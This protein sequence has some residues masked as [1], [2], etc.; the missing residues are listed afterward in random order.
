MILESLTRAKEQ[1]YSDSERWQSW[2]AGIVIGN[3]IRFLEQ[4]PDTSG[5]E[6]EAYYKNRLKK[7]T[8]ERPHNQYINV[9]TSFGLFGLTIFLFMLIYPMTFAFFWKQ[10]LIP[11]SLSCNCSR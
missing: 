10:P 11:V 1:Q 5:H 7:E 6:L 9:F 4:A 8:F 3:R 2:R